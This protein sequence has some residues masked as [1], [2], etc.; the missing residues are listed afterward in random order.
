MILCVVVELVLTDGG[1]DGMAVQAHSLPTR[2]VT[3]VLT[4]C[5]D[6]TKRLAGAETARPVPPPPPETTRH[7]ALK[8]VRKVASSVSLQRLCKFKSDTE[9][10]NGPRGEEMHFE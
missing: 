7:F 8:V 9:F 1:S 2:C 6:N 10:A 5:R 4:T 3:C